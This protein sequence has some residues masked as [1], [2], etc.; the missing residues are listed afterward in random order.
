M[1]FPEANEK[2]KQ[3]G[4]D[5]VV[6]AKEALPPVY[7]L[8]DYGKYQY[9]Q[10]KKEQKTR[11]IKIKGIRVSFRTGEHDLLVKRKKAE[12]FLKK[13]DKVRV[14][15]FLRGR[16]KA[17]QRDARKRLKEFVESIEENYKLEQ[18]IKKSPR[19]FNLLISP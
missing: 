1:S 16:E 19:G 4:L 15:I 13:G 12:S 5:L 14:E 8:M 2:A 17:F 3:Q 9:Q 18:S 11:Q 7:R 10:R 6:V